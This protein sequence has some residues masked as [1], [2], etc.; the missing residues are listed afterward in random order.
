MPNICKAA[1]IREAV[2]WSQVDHDV[3]LSEIDRLGRAL[4]LHLR[5]HFI[6]RRCFGQH[7]TAVID[8]NF[9]SVGTT[10]TYL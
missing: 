1:N 9:R 4:R 2:F 3:N 10:V 7:P 5:W 6:S 8:S